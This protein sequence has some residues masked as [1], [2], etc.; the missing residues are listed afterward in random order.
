MRT[1]DPFPVTVINQNMKIYCTQ[2]HY[3][4]VH[5]FGM[6]P[7]PLFCTHTRNLLKLQGRLTYKILL[8]LAKF[9][10][11]ASKVFESKLTKSRRLITGALGSLSGEAMPEIFSFSSHHSLTIMKASAHLIVSQ[12]ARSKPIFHLF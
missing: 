6:S 7:F 4:C 3:V 1:L 5:I 12:K 2:G 8:A 9:I 11:R 10:Q